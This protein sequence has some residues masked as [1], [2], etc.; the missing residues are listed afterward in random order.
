MLWVRIS[1]FNIPKLIK[2]KVD[3][4]YWGLKHTFSIRVGS[5][6]KSGRNGPKI[7]IQLDDLG[8]FVASPR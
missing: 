3:W 6:G 7:A 2:L 5:H 1:P 4:F 8:V